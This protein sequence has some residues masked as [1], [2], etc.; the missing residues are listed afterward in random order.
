MLISAIIAALSARASLGG[1]NRT[2]VRRVVVD[3]RLTLR[4]TIAYRQFAD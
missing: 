1:T 3:D 4:S 2:I